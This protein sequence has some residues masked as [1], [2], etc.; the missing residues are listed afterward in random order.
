MKALQIANGYCDSK[1]YPLLFAKLEIAG[2]EN[3]VFVPVKIGADVPPDEGADIVPCFSQIDRLSFYSKQRNLLREISNRRYLE[4]GVSVVHAHTLFSAGYAAWRLHKENGLPYIVAVRNTDVNVFFKYMLHLRHVGVQIMQD[5]YRV[6][7]LSSAYLE[8]TLDRYVPRSLQ[9]SIRQKSV[10][11]PNGIDDYFLEN[12]PQPRSAAATPLR[13]LYAGDLDAN[14]NLELTVQATKLL[15]EQG[16][17]VT[18]TA[19][20]QIL[21]EKYQKI[22]DETPFIAYYPRCPKEGV[23]EHLR[24]TDIFV[25]PSHKETF[26]LVYAEAMSQGVPVLYT[27][28]QGFDGQFPE[29]TV[30]YAVS[31]TD[32]GELAEKIMRITAEYP[33]LSEGCLANVQRFDWRKIAEEYKKIYQDAVKEKGEC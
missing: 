9:H 4:D 18:L 6:V 22:I 16:V 14:K 24:Q 27:R 3:R 7:F 8:Q 29:G 33:N 23:L 32:P 10:V 30:G 15:R 20:G 5:A 21:E 13:L 11:I 26:G 1:L 2:I 28:G 17:E 31:D 12:R 25:M 19:V